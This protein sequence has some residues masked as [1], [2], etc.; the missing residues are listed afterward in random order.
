MIGTLVAVFVMLFAPEPASPPELI[1]PFTS[2]PVRSDAPAAPSDLIDP[3]SHPKRRS[4]P[5][6]DCSTPALRDPFSPLE[7]R[8]GTRPFPGLRDPFSH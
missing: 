4:P 3:F 1:D 7:R 8:G 2:R 5:P 6:V